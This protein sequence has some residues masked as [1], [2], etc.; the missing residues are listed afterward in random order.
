M[1]SM[2]DRRQALFTERLQSLR[3]RTFYNPIGVAWKVSN[4]GISIRLD[5]LPASG[6]CV[7]FPP[8]EEEGG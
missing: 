5:A 8:R 4:D 3:G 7:L 6:E 1:A 2:R